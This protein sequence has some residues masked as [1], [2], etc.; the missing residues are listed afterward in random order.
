MYSIGMDV[1]STTAKVVV[2]D[3]RQELVFHRYVRHHASIDE[4]V[5][6]L[7][8]EISVAIG[9]V[10]A[11]M[12]VTGSA[13]MGVA[14]R[15]GLPFI[16]ELL[17]SSEFVARHCP[18]VRTLIDMGGE[19]TKMI[20]FSDTRL[21]DIRMNGNCAGGTGAFI[22][23]MA[24]LFDVTP[25][26][27]DAL[28]AGHR[29]L[30]PIASRCGVFAKTDVQNLLSRKVPRADIAYSVY[31]AVAMQSINTLSRGC[32]T[33]PKI[34]FSGGPFSFLPTLS[35]AFLSVLGLHRE[36]CVQIA[37]PE[38]VP[39][40]GAALYASARGGEVYP[41]V[42]ATRLQASSALRS[43]GSRMEPI[44]ASETAH[45]AWKNERKP[46]AFNYVG[47]SEYTGEQAFLGIDAG[48]TTTKIVLTGTQDELLYHFYA[49]NNGQM[50]ETVQQGL[51]RLQTFLAGAPHP[52]RIVAEAV[53]G[54]GEDLVRSA[55]GLSYGLVE[56]L[57]H[58]IASCR[59]NPDVSFILDIGGQDMKAFF[60]RDRQVRRIELNESCSSGCGSFIEMFSRSLGYDVATFAEMACR[61]TAPCDLGSRCT[62]FMNSRVKQALRENASVEDIAAGLSYSVVR[63]ALYK[64]LNMRDLN[65]LG[66]H[67]MVQG[68]TFRNQSVRRAFEL[69]TGRPTE[70]TDLPEMMGAYGAA[71]YA[72][73]C[74]EA[75]ETPRP[76]FS[77]DT[78]EEASR[79]DTFSRPCRGC[80]NRCTVSELRFRNG[81]RFYS[82]N[83]CEN[84]FHNYG[85]AD[86]P[87]ENL[88]AWK[89]QQ[90]FAEDGTAV[91]AEQARCTVGIPRALHFYEKY[92][93][94]RTLLGTAG[95]RTVLSAPSTVEVYR[96]GKG[97]I[98][99]DNICFPAKLLHG[100]VADLAERRTDRILYPV[101]VYETREYDDASDTFNCPI[102][103]GYSDVIGSAFDLGGQGILLDTPRVN[104]GDVRLLGASCKAY[105]MTL[106]V[107]AS[108]AAEAFRRALAAQTAFK[109]QLRVRAAGLIARA[110]ERKKPLIVLAGRPY[111][112]D[113]LIN[114][115]VPD[116]LTHF[117]AHVITE[118]MVPVD[119]G[120]VKG[121]HVL[122]QW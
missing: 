13:A 3:E 56:T 6:G 2:L 27:F 80:E 103:S 33:M 76:P 11:C 77:W 108:V 79:Y 30:C 47:L 94:W 51:Q 66:D 109:L 119:A 22:D 24:M 1:G 23:Q 110:V 28:A 38:L 82:G 36:D 26:A 97:T 16:Q 14:E 55:F 90:L 4:A 5:S 68:G 63:N 74:A 91:P 53:T 41:D 85:E 86:Q 10:P 44:F 117:G 70:M 84:I 43:T 17:A 102:V 114:S 31:Y 61:A 62:V 83:K 20:F 115:K 45:L 49:P 58:Y 67:V 121:L 37:H 116:I 92:P 46:L 71:L 60:I 52:V 48:S 35:D 106:G 57:A 112:A 64:V 118:D 96:K 40:W 32:E 54:Y 88:S 65:E 42:L 87:G 69:L 29:Q 95:I 100:H 122:P 7:C 107:P 19:D 15:S 111:H 99:S 98:M 93:F 18:E 9:H 78:V 39:A 105:L 34:L 101:A 120:A 75:E 21:P 50:V 59:F 89:L 25:A 104:F 8:R 113:L 72:R 81:R 12:A 73:Q